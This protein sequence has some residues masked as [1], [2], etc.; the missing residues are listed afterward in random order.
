MKYDSEQISQVNNSMSL[1]NYANQYLDLQLHNGEYWAVCPFH[2]DINASLSFN[3]EKNTYFC[4]GCKSGGHLISFIMQ[5]KNISF[6]QAIEYILKLSNIELREREYSEICNYLNKANISTKKHSKN[7][8]N[9]TYLSEDIMNQYTKEPIKEWLSVGISQE[10]L[11]KYNVRYDKRGN[12]IVFP[13]RDKNGKIIAV[14]ARTLYENFDDLG[15]R[16]YKYYQPIGTNDFLF[17]LWESYDS[18]MR[19]KEVLVF[20]GSKGKMT[21]ESFGYD[22]SVSL[23]TNSI[24]DFQL[25]ILLSLKVSIVMCLDKGMNIVSCKKNKSVDDVDIG[26]LPMMTDVYVLKDV[27]NSLEIKNTPT[28]KGKEV[29]DKLYNNRYK[30]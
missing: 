11:D 8:L 12:A 4:F 3:E 21:V 30:F 9:R 29:F 17:G 1:I 7:T 13:I 10:V 24:N 19:K 28:D 23:E 16:K 25:D 6:P 2:N 14:K 27:D 26:L 18:I 20:E 22:N 15:I 5:H